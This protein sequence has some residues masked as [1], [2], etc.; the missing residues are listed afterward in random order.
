M[1]YISADLA[2][3]LLPVAARG[4][5]EGACLALVLNF[6]ILIL[7]VSGIKKLVSTLKHKH[8]LNLKNWFAKNRR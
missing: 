8:Y 1:W 6:L 4:D 7:I 2:D 5:I 3:Q